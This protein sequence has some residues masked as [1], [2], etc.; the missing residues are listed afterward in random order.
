MPPEVRD[1]EF[2]Q[3]GVTGSCELPKMG[4][5]S[6]TQGFSRPA[7]LLTTEPALQPLRLFVIEVIY[8]YLCSL[9][10][11]H[12]CFNMA[13]WSGVFMKKF[14]IFFLVYVIRESHS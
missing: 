2:P 14:G 8:Q 6:S 4:P 3:A 13:D 1:V 12:M 9:C 7:S 10:F 11:P 5:G